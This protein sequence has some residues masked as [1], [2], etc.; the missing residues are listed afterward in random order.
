[1]VAPLFLPIALIYLYIGK[2]FSLYLRPVLLV[3]SR[4]KEWV[5]LDVYLIG[6]G[7]AAI[8]LQDYASVFIGNGLIAFITMTLISLLILIHLNIE[9]LWRTFYPKR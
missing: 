3:L 1:I 8:K 6:V 2:Y 9:Q 5:M 7:I 4:L